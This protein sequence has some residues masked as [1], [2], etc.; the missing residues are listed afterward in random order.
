MFSLAVANGTVKTANELRISGFNINP[1][2]L[3]TT[4]MAFQ[5]SIMNNNINQHQQLI[6]ALV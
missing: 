1:R 3:A 6:M 2:V 5:A 4:F